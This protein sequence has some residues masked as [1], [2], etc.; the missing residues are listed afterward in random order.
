[1]RRLIILL[2]L[3]LVACSASAPAPQPTY[4]PLPTYTPYPTFTPPLDLPSPSTPRATAVATA[5]PTPP[6]TQPAPT[7]SAATCISWTEAAAHIGETTCVRGVV[8][9]AYKDAQSGVFFIDFDNTRTSFY[10]VLFKYTWD[11]LQGKCVE[12]SGKI[13]PYRDRPEV[14][15]E[16]E[17]QLAL[18]K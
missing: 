1:V 8:Y 14:V 15:I 3:L 2:A 5:K 17:G 18:C 16:S 13:V 12:V 9:S 10:A 6:P 11:N 4:T 7:A